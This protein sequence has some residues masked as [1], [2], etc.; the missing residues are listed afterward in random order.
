MALVC[1]LKTSG[2]ESS[3][4][5][6]AGEVLLEL[7]RHEVVGQAFRVADYDVRPGVAVDEGHGDEW[8]ILRRHIVDSDIV[9]LATTCNRR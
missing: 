9:I 8:P 6:L 3:S 1:T 2:T 7:A 5:K 4:E